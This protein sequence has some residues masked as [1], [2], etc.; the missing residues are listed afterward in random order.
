[1]AAVNLSSVGVFYGLAPIHLSHQ[2]GRLQRPTRAHF[3]ADIAYACVWRPKQDG[4]LG[5]LYP[6]ELAYP[7]GAGVLMSRGPA[8]VHGPL[9]ALRSSIP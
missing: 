6:R 3:F 5:L 8:S 7:T 2:L 9:Q 4:G 1:M